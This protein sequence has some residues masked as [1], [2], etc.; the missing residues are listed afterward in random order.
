MFAA[1]Y[2]LGSSEHSKMMVD[3]RG[4]KIFANSPKGKKFVKQKRIHPLLHT[5]F[6]EVL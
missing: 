3:Q 2:L 6:M 1:L 5:D 4:P